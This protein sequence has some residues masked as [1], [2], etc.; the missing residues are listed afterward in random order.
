MTA[1]VVALAK[2]IWFDDELFRS[3][4]TG[5][6]LSKIRPQM[7]RSAAR[8]W[9]EI[10]RNIDKA[11]AR[12]KGRLGE[13][14][15]KRAWALAFFDAPEFFGGRTDP[16]LAGDGPAFVQPEITKVQTKSLGDGRR[17]SVLSDPRGF[18]MTNLGTKKTSDWRLHR[19][20]NLWIER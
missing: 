9:T 19:T 7:T 11:S 12:L 17:W 3:S 13:Q 14:Q 16:P 20:T 5:L 15:L 2:G 10:A 4:D 8:D 6:L 1:Q 18:A